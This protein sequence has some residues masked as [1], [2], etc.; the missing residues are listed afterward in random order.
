MGIEILEKAQ[1]AATTSPGTAVDGPAAGEAPVQVLFY[2]PP[3]AAFAFAWQAAQPD[4]R[5]LFPL[6]AE[7]PQLLYYVC[8]RLQQQG[9]AAAQVL[10]AAGQGAVGVTA[11]S[12]E[13]PSTDAL[14]L[15]PFATHPADFGTTLGS[16]APGATLTLLTSAAAG[17]RTLAGEPNLAGAAGPELIGLLAVYGNGRV[18]AADRA[19]VWNA[20]GTASTTGNIWVGDPQTGSATILRPAR[21]DDDPQIFPLGI[22]PAS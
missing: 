8:M 21:G 2:A 19:V 16:Y 20:D 6:S 10:I 5:W 11:A 15:L 4:R 18:I 12:A 1:L 3:A 22:D 17:E 9:Y 13:S 7:G 14:G